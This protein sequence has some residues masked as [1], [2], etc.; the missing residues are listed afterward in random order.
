MSASLHLVSR[1]VA[2]PPWKPSRFLRALPPESF[3]RLAPVLEVVQLPTRVVLWEPDTPIQH[4]YF[5]H[6]CAM[7]VIVLLRDDV[8]VE[9]HTIGRE[10]FLGAPVLFGSDTASTRAVVQVAGE[11]SRLSSSAFRHALAEDDAL[12]RF[13]LLY[14]H[15]VLDQTSQS[16]AC[17]GRHE[18]P[19]RCARWLL[20]T[21]DRVDRDEFRL[22]QEYLAT[23]LGVRRATVTGAALMLHRAGLIEYSR[24]RVTILDR[25]GLEKVSCECYDVV[26]KRYDL[27]LGRQGD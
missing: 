23:M 25:D 17:N 18:L 14:A 26:R 27:L 8:C 3:A 24:G 7:S 11:A 12:R 22:T 20:M 2:P 19:K 16:V 4:V 5:P 13:S 9:A 21:R 6:S 15:V 1:D 10:G